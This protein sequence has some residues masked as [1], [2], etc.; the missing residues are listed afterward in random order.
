M[1]E[2]RQNIIR[3][4]QELFAASYMFARFEY[5]VNE[6]MKKDNA[7]DAESSTKLELEGLCESF[8]SKTIKDYESCNHDAF[9]H[10][11]C[12]VYVEDE[13]ETHPE[14]LYKDSTPLLEGEY[15]TSGFDATLFIKQG[16]EVKLSIME[17]MTALNKIGV[18][19]MPNSYL[20]QAQDH[21]DKALLLLHE[22]ES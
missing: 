17:T 10:F 21:L 9:F 15:N 20:S 2:T 13:Y 1:S 4:G 6:S 19:L 18:L 16:V 8:E 7:T 12:D 5:L 14:D 22:I 11:L 3:I